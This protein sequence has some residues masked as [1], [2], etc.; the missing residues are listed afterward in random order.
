MLHELCFGRRPFEGE[1][2]LLVLDKIRAAAPPDVRGVPEE[3]GEVILRCLAR[4]PSARFPS[5]EALARTLGALRRLSPPLGPL[6]VA[7]WVAERRDLGGARGAVPQT[8][9]LT[10]E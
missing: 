6:D 3:L 4:D 9:P 5:T 2:P 1:T 8:L 7:A 10:E